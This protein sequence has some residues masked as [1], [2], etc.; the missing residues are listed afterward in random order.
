MRTIKLILIFY[1]KILA[2]SIIVSVMIQLLTMNTLERFSF[3]PF[4]LAYM[5]SAPLFIFFNYE[6]R[7]TNEYYFYYNFG[8]N[9]VTLWIS[10]I[11]IS[12]IIGLT[13]SVIK[14]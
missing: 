9:K 2:P 14:I 13:L 5:F 6:V 4:G 12:L 3:L 11:V 8:L 1:R 7:N 10:T